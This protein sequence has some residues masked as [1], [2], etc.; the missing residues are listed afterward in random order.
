[1]NL[2]DRTSVTF[3]ELS[4]FLQNLGQALQHVLSKARYL[5]V[6]GISNMTLDTSNVV[7]ALFNML[8][9]DKRFARM[10]SAGEALPDEYHK[11]IVDSRLHMASVD[12]QEELYLSLLDIELHARYEDAQ[13]LRAL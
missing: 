4:D 2:R 11:K 10:L 5:E 1:M 13:I 9:L 8:L 6:S 12:L 3:S 7:P